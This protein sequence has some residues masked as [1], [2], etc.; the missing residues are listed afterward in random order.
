MIY[1]LNQKMWTLKDKFAITDDAG[2]TCFFVDTNWNL[3][4]VRKKFSLF[5]TAGREVYYA[6]QRILSFLARFD[7]YPNSGAVKEE[8]IGFMRRSPTPWPRYRVKTKYGNYVV[9][10]K[11]GL[12]RTLTILKNGKLVATVKKKNFQIRDQYTIEVTEPSESA[13]ALMIALINDQMHY[14]GR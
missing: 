2:R 10:G 8:R 12:A 11:F 13:L 7:L 1:I 3:L 9:K 6:Q 14:R 5:D 4:G